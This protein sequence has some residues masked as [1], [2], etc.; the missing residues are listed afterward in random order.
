MVF[1]IAH[2]L[3][4]LLISW[5]VMTTTH[6]VGHLVGGWCSG[7]TLAKA[8]LWPWHLPYSLFEPDPYPLVTLWCGPVLGVLVPLTIGI[9]VRR[10]W[11]WFISFFCCLANGSYLA[12]AWMVGDRYLDT[13]R[14]LQHGASP[15]ALAVFCSLTIGIGYVGFRR[16]CVRFWAASSAEPKVESTLD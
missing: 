10:D 6:E 7:A 4:L 12:L 2:F 16:C 3:G 5:C 14:L 8:D 13:F 15:I 9:C 1:R 11:A